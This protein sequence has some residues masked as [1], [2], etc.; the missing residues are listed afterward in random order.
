MILYKPGDRAKILLRG[1]RWY[2]KD[3]YEVI[4]QDASGRVAL[5]TPAGPRVYSWTV[6]KKWVAPPGTPL[7][8]SPSDEEKPDGS[9]GL[10]DFFATRNS[11]RTEHRCPLCGRFGTP[12]FNNFICS[13]SECRNG[14]KKR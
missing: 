11:D 5:K 2:N 14:I 10:F 12:M 4:S 9:Q 13:D 7:P 8:S 3:Y 1:S 6:L